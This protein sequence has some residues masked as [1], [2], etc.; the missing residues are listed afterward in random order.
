MAL[1]TEI[2]ATLVLDTLSA[3][4]A[5]REVRSHI[6]TLK[7]EVGAIDSKMKAY[8]VTAD[9]L[10]SILKNLAQQEAEQKN[11]L[12]KLTK[13]YDEA[14]ASGGKT[15]K[16]LDQM[17]S[18]I[19]QAEKKLNSITLQQQHYNKELDSLNSKGSKTTAFF[20]TFKQA[21]TD[22]NPT[23]GKLVDG[24]NG[25]KLAFGTLATIAGVEI[26]KAVKA[27]V[28]AFMEYEDAFAG[29]RKTI[30]G[31]E[32]DF[33]NINA[34]IQQLAREI[35]KSA[36]Q[37]A[38]MAK[39]GGQLGIAS[40][41]VVDFAEVVLRLADT[42][43]VVAE[44][45]GEMIAQ[46]GAITGLDSSDYERFG[47]T[48]VALGNSASATEKEILDMSNRIARFSQSAK[49]SNQEILALATALTSMGIEAEAGGTSLQKMFAKLTLAVETGS[50][51]LNGFASV[52]GMSAEEFSKLYKQS[53]IK[54]LQA[55]LKG[56]NN[57][58]K[59]S[60]SYTKTL[61]DLDIIEG[62]L[63]AVMQALASNQD[64]L[65][66]ALSLAQTAWVENSELARSSGE[67]YD[68]LSSTIQVAKNN[69][70]EL[71]RNIGSLFA[72]AISEVVEKAGSFAKGINNVINPLDKSTLAM[73][74]AKEAIANYGTALESTKGGLEGFTE[75]QKTSL[76]IGLMSSLVETKDAWER[77]ADKIADT[78]K[79]LD[80]LKTGREGYSDA[81][82]KSLQ[83]LYIQQ[84]R[85][86]GATVETFEEARQAYLDMIGDSSKYLKGMESTYA[87]IEAL[88]ANIND[89][90]LSASAYEEQR[91]QHVEMWAEALN[92]GYVSM[93]QLNRLGEDFAKSVKETADNLAKSAKALEDQEEA[94]SRWGKEISKAEQD[95]IDKVDLLKES[96]EGEIDANDQLR[97]SLTNLIAEQEEI[98][99]QFG[100]NTL[101]YDKA[102]KAIK[103]YKEAL[104][105]ITATDIETM[106]GELADL[107][108]QLLSTMDVL[109]KDPG[110]AILTEKV[111]E[112]NKA[113]TEKQLEIFTAQLEQLL[114]AGGDPDEILAIADNINKLT[115]ATKGYTALEDYTD[116]LSS[117]T[118]SYGTELEKAELK[119]QQLSNSQAEYQ[120]LLDKA[121]DPAIKATLQ[122][123]VDLYDS[124]I[125]SAT[126]A[127]D[128]LNAPLDTDSW[129]NSFGTEAQK[130]QVKIDAVTDSIAEMKAELTKEGADT[131]LL[132]SLIDQAEKQ[133]TELETEMA[134]IGKDASKSFMEALVPDV[135]WTK[136]NAEE[137]GNYI[138]DNLLDVA[139][140]ISDAI[141]SL[142]DAT[143]QADIDAKKA[144]ITALEEQLDSTMEAME[145]QS[146]EAKSKLEAQYQAG[147][148]TEVEY[149]H[150]SQK[151]QAEYE[152]AKQKAEAETAQKK[153]Q[154]LKEQ[155]AIEEAQFNANKANS[156]AQVLIDSA[157]A[158]IKGWTQGPVVGASTTALMAGLTAMQIAQINAQKYVPAL[159]QGGIT[160]GPTMALIGDNSSGREA[161]IPL[162][163]S[164]M[165][166][167]ASEIL[168]GMR[169][170]NNTVYNNSSQADDNRTYTI[171]Q[172]ITTPRGMTR[173]EAYLQA[174][175]ALKET[176]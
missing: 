138:R 113:I 15:V 103:V 147:Y 58:D 23:L 137:W 87:S 136:W 150:K 35:P 160:T 63:S 164:T 18:N 116:T 75:A 161:V 89:L 104:D 81:S 98:R 158:I 105:S 99:K 7:D 114:T 123:I 94:T 53:S 33:E 149:Y 49:L 127:R 29:I 61:A 51:E 152:K 52:V 93:A 78:K 25:A 13:E 173:R 97:T 38:E 166:M 162:E 165:R 151:Q 26:V 100:E 4:Q 153:A 148:I 64:G 143:Y 84:A 109:V 141:S 80:R 119:I 174:R 79:E 66:D 19:A 3:S 101:E 111:Q 42:T 34:E 86:Q 56:M 69:F 73:D 135:D 128:N 9:D 167:L 129:V 6:K 110:N 112:L 131:G 122:K 102:T 17:R 67:V 48:L 27:G 170:Q 126:E 28:Q 140:Q 120:A 168:K 82:L 117:V 11:L 118:S 62:R 125:D 8:G 50:E 106:Q 47:S 68:T 83:N 107:N 60:Q 130:L 70:T 10:T 169:T 139:S 57:L 156:I 142:L 71:S 90:E 21:L 95:A 41:D 121:T 22:I 59:E 154:L 91:T 31:T 32:T 2:G 37:I 134:N 44:S 46:I 65:T 133:K 54:G 12:A 96:V 115:E 157:Q 146:D 43:N 76:Q 74:N 24:V 16:Q 132:N 144:E 155:Q 14:T 1:N 176:R 72:P 172:S 40:D 85:A 55:L 145:A 175:K 45:A 36:S 77:L 108:S 30:N 163:Q 20:N 39:L 124:A 5:I 171:N 159:A 92:A 88:Q